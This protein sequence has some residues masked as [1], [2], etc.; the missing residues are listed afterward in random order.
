M[1]QSVKLLEKMGYELYASMGTGDYYQ[2]HGV[3]VGML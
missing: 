1:L 3:Q 2:E